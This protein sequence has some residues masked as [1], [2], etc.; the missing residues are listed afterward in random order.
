MLEPTKERRNKSA[1]RDD[2]NCFE[3]AVGKT[4]AGVGTYMSVGD[5]FIYLCS[6]VYINPAA[7][8]RD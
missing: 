6:T 1:E 5:F 3:C 8:R 4:Y 7:Q 2:D